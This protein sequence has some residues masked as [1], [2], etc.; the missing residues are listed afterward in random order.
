LSY[1]CHIKLLIQPQIYGKFA[2]QASVAALVGFDA[3][4]SC[5]DI[6]SVAEVLMNPFAYLGQLAGEFGGGYATHHRPLAPL[7]ALEDLAGCHKLCALVSCA[8][9][10]EM[11]MEGLYLGD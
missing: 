2:N 5:N 10:A 3:P 9:H 7:Q 8:C 4:S 1:F 6:I 11:A